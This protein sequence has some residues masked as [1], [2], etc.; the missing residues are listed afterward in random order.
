MSVQL[1]H[2]SKIDLLRWDDVV[3]RASNSRVYAESWF[4]DI[5]QPDWQGIIYGNYEYVMP[6]IVAKKWGTVYIYQP[7]Y[8][9]QHGIYPTATPKIT[10]EIL[11]FIQ[12]SFSYFNLSLN[13]LNVDV[14]QKYQVEFRKNYLLSL[15][16]VM[17]EIRKGYNKHTIR[18]VK[19]AAKE[20]EIS[21]LVSIEDYINLKQKHS[22]KSFQSK[23]LDKLR[24]I[25]LKAMKQNCGIIYGAYSKRNELIAAAFFLVEEKRITY[26]NSVSTTEGKSS[27][28]MYAIVDRFIQDHA[29]SIYLLDFEGSNIDGIARFFMGFGAQPE[30][31]QHIRYN[32]LP[33]YMKVFK[34]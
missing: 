3:L 9:Q 25:L 17:D 21:T 32:A 18:Y 29:G 14:S 4:L 16:P 23:D 1:L 30:I 7:S 15:H 20:C 6:V 27:R 34:K 12:K 33:W 5:I 22:H 2:N 28:A 31:Y 24:L 10:L 11:A 26:L 13:A 19:K 8:A